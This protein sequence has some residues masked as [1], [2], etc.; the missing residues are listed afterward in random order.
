MIFHRISE[1]ILATFIQRYDKKK[2]KKKKKYISFQERDT[3]GNFTSCQVPHFM[4]VY[5]YAT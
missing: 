1:L 3:N 4:I 2:K 5:I